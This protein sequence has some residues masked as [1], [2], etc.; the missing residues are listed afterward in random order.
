MIQ[1]IRAG[2]RASC[3]ALTLL[4]ALGGGLVQP[5]FGADKKKGGGESF[6]QLPTLTASLFHG[7]S[8]RGVLTVDV[9]VDVPDAGLRQKAGL[10]IPRLRAA[11]TQRLMTYAA[12]IPSAA[13]PDPDA[14]GR[15]LQATTDETLGRPGAKV[16]L[17]T[18]LIN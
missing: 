3:L 1:S 14:I 17:G 2:G 18:I 11:F 7:I 13:P 6:I 8:Q 4:L 15:L 16:L 10:V 12:S 9:G 5:A